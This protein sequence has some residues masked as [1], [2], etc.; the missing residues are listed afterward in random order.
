MS[1]LMEESKYTHQASELLRPPAGGA[2]ASDIR[3]ERNRQ[4]TRT[5]L[6]MN[7]VDNHSRSLH[8]PLTRRKLCSK[9]FEPPLNSRLSPARPGVRIRRRLCAGSR[10]GSFRAYENGLSRGSLRSC[11][12]SWRHHHRYGVAVVTANGRVP[13]AKT[14]RIGRDL[15]QRWCDRLSGQA[16]RPTVGWP[17]PRGVR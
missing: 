9:Q 15:V 17:N 11:G 13:C 1:W 4:A 6:A 10:L 2:H 3:S 8:Q 16:L 7:S 14:T 12:S 5:S